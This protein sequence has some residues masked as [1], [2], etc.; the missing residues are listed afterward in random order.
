[1]EEVRH[2][3]GSRASVGWQTAG[4]TRMELLSSLSLVLT[5]EICRSRLWVVVE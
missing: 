5:A 3:G 4:L 1:M 2:G